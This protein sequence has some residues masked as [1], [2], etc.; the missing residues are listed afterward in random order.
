MIQGNNKPAPSNRHQVVRYLGKSFVL[1]PM[2]NTVWGPGAHDLA[3]R[4]CDQLNAA[5]DTA[6]K[7]GK[8]KCMTCADE[9]LS[10]G[11]HNRMCDRCRSRADPLGGYA[12]SGQS[13]GRRPRALMK[14]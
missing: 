3:D 13:D 4:K 7:R 2:G 9:F 6:R 5:Q 1:D 14:G 11:I 12:Y 10:E 8:R